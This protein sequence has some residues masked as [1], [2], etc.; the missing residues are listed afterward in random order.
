MRLT[1]ERWNHILERHPELAGHLPDIL[2]AIEDPD[3][4]QS[5]PL[6]GEEWFF[7][8]TAGPSRW[9][10]VVVAFSETDGHIVTAFARRKSP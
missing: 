6:A 7:R 1:V 9:L 10:Q 8:A 2:A 5:G 3:D 4:V